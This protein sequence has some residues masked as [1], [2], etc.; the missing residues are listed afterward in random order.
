MSKLE[1]SKVASPVP[2]DK[3]GRHGEMKFLPLRI[4]KYQA[5]NNDKDGQANGQN[6]TY[7]GSYM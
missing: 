2:S 4:S 6:D 1:L 7:L 3:T 5:I